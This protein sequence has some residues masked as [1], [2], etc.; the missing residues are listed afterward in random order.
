MWRL[1]SPPLP[2]P[3]KFGF[4]EFPPRMQNHEI[5]TARGRYTQRA[6]ELD[7]RGMYGHLSAPFFCWRSAAAGCELCFG[8]RNG[9]TTDK[10][11]WS[12]GA[13]A[14]GTTVDATVDQQRSAI[15]FTMHGALGHLVHNEFCGESVGAVGAGMTAAHGEFCCRGAG[16]VA[17]GTTAQQLGRDGVGAARGLHGWQRGDQFEPAALGF[18]IAQQLGRPNGASSEGATELALELATSQQ[19][20]CCADTVEN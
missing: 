11:H 19:K 5:A 13:G 9:L 17:A 12:N 3:S 16:A 14:A 20:P 7:I 8:W 18:T 4:L 15:R 2:P 10:V 6:W 1:T